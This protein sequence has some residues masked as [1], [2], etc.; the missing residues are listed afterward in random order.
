LSEAMAHSSPDQLPAQS[1]LEEL[2]MLCQQIDKT[3]RMMYELS[4]FHS[5]LDANGTDFR[6]RLLDDG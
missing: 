3:C 4:Q 1:D 6:R 5:G 2:A